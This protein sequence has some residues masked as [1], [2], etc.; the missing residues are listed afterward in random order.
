[1]EARG[2]AEAAEAA[3]H[4]LASALT[5]AGRGADQPGRDDRDSRGGRRAGHQLHE[6]F[7][8]DARRPCIAASPL[9]RRDPSLVLFAGCAF[10]Q[11]RRSLSQRSCG[12]SHA[13]PIGPAGR[14]A[15][16]RKARQNAP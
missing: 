2:G 6:M 14:V 15:T 10:D 12:D 9:A 4:H 3:I 11:D 1:M 13:D 5:L 16:L 8:A 7:L